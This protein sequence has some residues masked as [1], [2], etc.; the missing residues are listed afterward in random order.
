VHPRALYC[1][2]GR[3]DV[4]LGNC[5]IGDLDLILCRS[6]IQKLKNNLNLKACFGQ[7]LIFGIPDL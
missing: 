6:Q 2:S 4:I 1:T 3:M 7:R 5:L